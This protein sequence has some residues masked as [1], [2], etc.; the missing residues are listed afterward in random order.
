MTE[1]WTYEHAPD[2]SARFVLGTVGENPLVCFGINPSTAVPN[3]PDRT[4]GRVIRFAAANGFDSWTMLNVYPQIST[5]PT[6]M[7]LQHDPD[8]KAQN[9]HHI[10]RM[11]EGRPTLLAAWGVLVTSRP[12]LRS[13]LA[14][15]LKITTAAGAQWVSLGEPTKDGHPRHPLY[16]SADTPLVP[17]D[18]ERYLA[19]SRA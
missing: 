9:E 18:V 3:A 13:L 12:Y 4:V 14:D 11:V 19:S 2:G 16:L 6:G 17:F 5:D 7:H 1:Q 10:A 15:I 8:L